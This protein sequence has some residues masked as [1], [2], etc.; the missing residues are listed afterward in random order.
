[1]TLGE[2]GRHPSPRRLIEDRIARANRS[3]TLYRRDPKHDLELLRTRVHFGTAGAALC[4]V[5]IAGRAYRESTLR[6]LFGTA[7]T[8]DTLNKIHFL[9][10][11]IGCRDIA[12]NTKLDLNTVYA[13]S[14][15][16]TKHIGTS[17]QDSVM[18]QMR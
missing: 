17:S 4:L 6:S 8:I 9:K 1:M 14:A 12:D 16:K 10:R 18:P 3:I 7:R 15:G 11:P 13:C 5:D 2:V